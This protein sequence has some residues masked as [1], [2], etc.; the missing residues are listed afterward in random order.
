MNTV[1]IGGFNDD[2]IQNLA[3]LTLRY[4]VDGIDL[5]LELDE[6]RCCVEIELPLPA[7]GE[8]VWK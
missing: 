8:P 4:P 2:E 5:H 1:L 3:E 6:E 7:R